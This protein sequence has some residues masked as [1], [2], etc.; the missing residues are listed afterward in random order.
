MKIKLISLSLFDLKCHFGSIK[1]EERKEEK[2]L[3]GNEI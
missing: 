1:A 2:I 3:P